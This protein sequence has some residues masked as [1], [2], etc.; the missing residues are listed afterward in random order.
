VASPVRV[1][2]SVLH[3]MGL[4]FASCLITLIGIELGLRYSEPDP[5]HGDGERALFVFDPVLGWA[6]R[7]NARGQLRRSEFNYPVAINSLGMRDEEF[8][9]KRGDEFRVAFLGDSIGWGWGVPDGQRFTE[10]VENLNPWIN[11]LNFGVSGYGPLQYLLQLDHVL[12]LKPDF[13]IVTFSLGSDLTDLLVSDKGP[14]PYARLTEDLR[15]EIIGYPLPQPKAEKA[16]ILQL[17]ILDLLEGAADK[18]GVAGSEYT[19]QEPRQGMLYAPPERLT[20]EEREM[21][22][23]VY[24]ANDVIL[25]SMRNKIQAALGPDRFAVLLAP[26]VYEYGRHLERWP[27]A[28]RNAVANRMQASLAR[29]KITMIDGRDVIESEDFWS[30]DGHWKPSGHEKIAALLEHFLARVTAG[31]GPKLS[32]DEALQVGASNR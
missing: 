20:S 19:F 12:S 8:S 4:L 6:N 1:K 17:R 5:T 27:N 7:P 9:D 31:N 29:L 10:V 14:Q 24:Q 18:L 22:A 32:A 28:D 26:T 13:V 30:E 23:F 25:E 11:A 3:N 16:K 21:A 15:L 2:K